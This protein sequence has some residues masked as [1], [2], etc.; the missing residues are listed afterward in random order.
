MTGA[1]AVI[2]LFLSGCSSKSPSGSPDARDSGIDAPI[3][4]AGP[5]ADAAGPDADAPSPTAGCEQDQRAYV[6]TQLAPDQQTDVT[7]TVR[8]VLGA[9]DFPQSMP[10]CSG[11]RP[12]GS[13]AAARD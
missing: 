12:T 13:G 6:N 11:D 9:T 7:A 2:A 1:L 8:A 3:D 4:A 10:Y 5:D